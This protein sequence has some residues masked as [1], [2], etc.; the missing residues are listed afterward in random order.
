MC[1]LDL[2]LTRKNV[3]N[4]NL[5]QKDVFCSV[6]SIWEYNVVLKVVPNLSMEFS[7][8]ETNVAKKTDQTRIEGLFFLPTLIS[9]SLHICKVDLMKRTSF[10]QSFNHASQRLKNI[11]FARKKNQS[12]FSIG[13]TQLT[14]YQG[15]SCIH[16][17]I[18]CYP[19][20]ENP[21]CCF[22]FNDQSYCQTICFYQTA[23]ASVWNKT[24]FVHFLSL[25][26][27]FAQMLLSPPAA[28]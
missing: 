4:T 20:R 16:S 14:F 10:P 13:A 26:P 19:L 6:W 1:N 22:L 9:L 18:F 23:T 8:V 7:E 25:P 17:V 3:Y 21:L 27:S 24:I 5:L 28:K 2:T 11:C 15:V 12:V